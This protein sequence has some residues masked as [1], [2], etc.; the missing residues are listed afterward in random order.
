MRTTARERWIGSDVRARMVGLSARVDGWT[1]GW[2]E[3][4]KE[5]KDGRAPETPT[6]VA[7]DAEDEGTNEMK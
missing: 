5:G 3:G 4:R 6:R 2:K 7:R 1:I